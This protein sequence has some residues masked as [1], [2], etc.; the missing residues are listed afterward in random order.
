MTV[1]HD[2]RARIQAKPHPDAKARLYGSKNPAVNVIAPL[3]ST[4]GMLIPYT[5]AIQVTWASVEY[6]QY[7]LPQTNFDYFAFTKRNS[8]MLSVVPDICCPKVKYVAI[9][10]ELNVVVGSSRFT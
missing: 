8:P 5:P 2:F 6:S 3:W 7:S 10:A 1:K 4:N 9:I